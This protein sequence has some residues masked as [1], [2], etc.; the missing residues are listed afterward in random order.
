MKKNTWFLRIASLTLIGAVGL[1]SSCKDDDERL[2]AE[3]TLA[4]TEEAI[5]D[6]YYEDVDDISSVVVQDTDNPSG[7]RSQAGGDERI[8]CAD[9]SWTE[10][11]N[12]SGGQITIDFGDG[13][14]VRGNKREGKIILT[15]SNGPRGNTGFKVI[16]TF[17]DYKIN[18]IELQGTRTVTRVLAS[19]PE[20]IKHSIKLE[21]GKAIWPDGTQATRISEF[22]REWVRDPEDERVILD[23]GA[24]GVT[25]RGKEYNMVISN[26]LVYRREC[27]LTEGIY[28]A[29]EGTKVFNTASKQITIDYGAGDC[30]RS[31]NISVSGVSRD[32]NVGSN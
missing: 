22:T 14:T 9:I 1:V 11:S 25:R 17:D 23:G 31:V 10:N 16:T 21:N 27:I 3:D 15:Y 4:I 28:M 32:V 12:S 26:V 6:S 30:D 24:L 7:G 5:S 20:N 18:G 13:C 29:V 19:D 8:S 2:T